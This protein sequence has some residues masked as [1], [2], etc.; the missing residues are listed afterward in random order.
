MI[1]ALKMTAA[2]TA[3]EGLPNRMM[4]SAP[5]GDTP[6]KA[7]KDGEILGQIVGEAEGDQRRGSSTSLPCHDLDQF[8]GLESRSTR[9]AALAAGYRIH[10][11]ATSAWAR[12]GARCSRRRVMAIIPPLAAAGSIPVSLASSAR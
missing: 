7:A 4:F 2:S 12:A 9:L 6:V 8:G 10:G 5:V 3:L 11:H 1:K